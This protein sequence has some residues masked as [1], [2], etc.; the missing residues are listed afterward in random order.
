MK[1][2]GLE[3]EKRAGRVRWGERDMRWSD[4]DMAANSRGGGGR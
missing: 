2:E 3:A 4:W 1:R